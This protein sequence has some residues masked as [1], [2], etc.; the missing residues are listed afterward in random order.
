MTRHSARK[1][2][3]TS[4]AVL[5][6]LMA[7]L[8]GQSTSQ[9]T[10]GDPSDSN[11][12]TADNWD[13]AIPDDQ[14]D[15][16]IGGGKTAKH[17]AGTAVAQSLTLGDAEGAGTLNLSG[18]TLSVVNSI[19]NGAGAS[20]LSVTGEPS[21][22]VGGALAVDTLDIGYNVASGNLSFT[23]GTRPSEIQIGTSQ[24]DRGRIIVGYTEGGGLSSDGVLN[25]AEVPKLT[26]YLNQFAIGW[27]SDTS[28]TGTGKGTVTLAEENS[29]DATS[30]VVAQNEYWNT[31]PGSTLTLGADNTFKVDTFTVAGYRAIGAVN[32]PSGGEL[33]LE[34][35][36]SAA[37]ANLFIANNAVGTTHDGV[38][39]MDLSAGT[40]NATLNQLRIGFH[41]S[42]GGSGTGTLSFADGEVTANSVVLGHT[43]SSSTGTGIGTLN[44]AGGSLAVA[45]N[46]TLGTGSAS[47]E[48]TINMTGG[49]FDV[50]GNVAG[51][52]GTSTLNIAGG[53]MTVDGNL[54][55][56]V[57]RVGHQGKTGTLTVSGNSAQIGS[58][59]GTSLLI[60]HRATSD[61]SSPTV[62]AMDLSDAG[63]VTIDTGTVALAYTSASAN[64]ADVSGTLTLSTTGNN[65]IT[66]DI[67]RLGHIDLGSTGD[68]TGT[69]NLGANNT[70]HTDTFVV[71]GDKALGIV[72]IADGGT[73]TLR[74]KAGGDTDPVHLLIGTNDNTNTG[75]NPAESHLNL[76]GG[77]FNATLGNVVIGQYA[78]TTSG[79]GSGKGRFTMDAGDVSA[80]SV[81]L[82]NSVGS[83]P[84]NTEG[85]LVIKGGSFD[86]AGDVTG[87]TGNSTI[88]LQ[89]GAMTV[90][91]NL[92]ANEL[93]VGDNGLTAGLTANGT[94]KTLSVGMLTVAADSGSGTLTAGTGSTVEIGS[95]AAATDLF[96]AR[97]TTTKTVTGTVDLSAANSLVAHL[98]RL[99]MA[100]QST[101]D[102][103]GSNTAMLKLGADNEIHAEHIILGLVDN[104][105]TT[106]TSATIELGQSN[107]IRANTLTIGGGKSTGTV[108]FADLV[109]GGVL[110]LGTEA[111][112]VDLNLGC[113]VP[114]EGSWYTG[115]TATGHLDGTGGTIHAWLDEVVV[116]YHEDGNGKG[117]GALTLE[118]GIVVA[119]SMLLGD[120]TGEN[121]AN[122]KGT[123]A[124]KGGALRAGSITQGA[125]QAVFDWTGGTLS[126]DHFGF[127]LLQADTDGPSTLAPGNSIGTTTIDGNY[128]MNA[129][130]L[131]IEIAASDDYDFVM[132][133]GNATLAG[134]L[135][136]LL[137]DDYAPALG[138]HFDVLQTTGELD[139]SGL[140]L[141]GDP[142][143]PT[144]GQ[145]EMTAIPGAGGDGFLL[146]LSAVPEPSSAVML[147]FAVAV[148][149]GRKRRK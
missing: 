24:S 66:A 144:F 43:T 92:I 91:G 126:V 94:A 17:A 115:T 44:M 78:G 45:N 130:T 129:G 4:I 55:V 28:G 10:D 65:A 1:A 57:L 141:T 108:K 54:A 25:L 6:G 14:T 36:S 27:R 2:F 82:A 42:G 26:A 39:T 142:P 135:N 16:Y 107:T 32:L 35:P 120:G 7:P 131:E 85:T 19:V 83:N 48:G 146:R 40:F 121:P 139:I 143:G 101:G 103:T 109:T 136:V 124:L 52:I 30:I 138:T 63:D 148:L 9:F 118:D 34:G 20:T 58:G 38:G 51:G 127:D 89:G 12:T 149:I 87:G 18:G 100:T 113:N 61:V 62:G 74:G 79:S 98:G 73:L 137:L 46:V 72:T 104:G 29:I 21:L 125:G 119:N 22:S 3:L 134:D 102:T 88:Q 47:S 112:R 15:A 59:S 111:A 37:A 49:T 13:P 11:W 86:V 53:A 67:I 147:V 68:V 75:T 23:S 106:T 105:A 90:D 95:A 110:N 56:D 122:N 31:D 41:A 93:I 116:G 97:K 33:N 145:W 123:I 133:E 64:E 60:G 71:G 114:L 132:V 76:S 84:G 99:F 8:Q 96:I 128:T 140:T 5:L 50:T 77:T 70:I 69:L 117:I 81:L 80:A